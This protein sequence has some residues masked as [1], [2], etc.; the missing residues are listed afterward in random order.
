MEQGMSKRI[1]VPVANGNEEMETV[2]I[3]DTLVRAGFQVTMAAVGDKFKC[4][5]HRG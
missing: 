4:K 2:I 3:V 5:A 1:L